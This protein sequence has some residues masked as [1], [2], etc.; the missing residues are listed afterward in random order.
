MK[1]FTFTVGTAPGTGNTVIATVVK[2][3]APT[4]IT[5]TLTAAL[6]TC[7]DATHQEVLA[8]NDVIAVQLTRTGT[9]P[10][11]STITTFSLGSNSPIAMSNPHTLIDTVAFPAAT[12]V[13]HDVPRRDG[14]QL[15]D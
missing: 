2:N 3:G 1:G 15:S 5:C 14:L 10:W 4:T 13:S 9:T 6:T 7:S 11:T 8:A 12:S